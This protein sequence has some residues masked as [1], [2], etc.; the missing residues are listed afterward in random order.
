MLSGNF[1]GENI[2]AAISEIRK[3]TDEY[4][5]LFGECSVYLEK[6][7]S[8]TLMYIIH[9]RVIRNYIRFWMNAFMRR[10]TVML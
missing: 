6:I 9:L 8:E 1:K 10:I 5:S 7:S 4:R 3:N 2:Q